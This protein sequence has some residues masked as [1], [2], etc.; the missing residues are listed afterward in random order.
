[1]FTF[2][3]V[4]NLVNNVDVEETKKKVESHKRENKDQIQHNKFKKV[5]THNIIVSLSGKQSHQVGAVFSLC[6]L[7]LVL[8]PFV[9]TKTP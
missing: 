2:S 6:N 1:M 4:F 5:A 9:D 7:S 3:P 8:I